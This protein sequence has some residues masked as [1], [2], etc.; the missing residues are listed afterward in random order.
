MPWLPLVNDFKQGLFYASLMVF[1]LVFAGEHLL[2]DDGT[3]N[4]IVI[5]PLI[6][7]PRMTNILSIV[8]SKKIISLEF[9]D[10]G[11][12]VNGIM[13]YSRQLAIVLFGCVCLFIFDL[14]ERGVQL[15]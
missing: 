2:N 13:S 15:K 4:T 9:V 8:F 11:G 3:G 14:C 10:S 12:P 1:W 6:P 7:S 5:Y